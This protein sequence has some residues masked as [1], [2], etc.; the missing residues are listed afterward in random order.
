MAETMLTDW[1]TCPVDLSVPD[2]SE[3]LKGRPW[4]VIVLWHFIGAPLVRANW[5][6]VS[7]VK[8]ALLKAFGAHIGVG[9][10]IKPGIKIKFPWYLTVG[11]HCWLGEDVWID[12]LAPVTIGSH[13]C[14][15]Q[16][17]YLCTGNHD[18]SSTN[19]K[20]FRRPIALQDGSWVGARAIVGPGTVVGAGAIVTAGSVITRDVPA[21]QIWS[22][23]PARYTR[24]RVVARRSAC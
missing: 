14:V 24:D 7:S 11:D 22:G 8:T 4:L 16:G 20:L 9:A 19:M 3:Y 21:G 6:P 2:N 5:L 17:A 13:V 15:S 1:R 18:W 23:N 12:N 10:Y